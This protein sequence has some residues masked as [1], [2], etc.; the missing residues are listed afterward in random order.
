MVVRV[1][2]T[3][4][5]LLWPVGLVRFLAY[6]LIL[7]GPWNPAVLTNFIMNFSRFLLK[8]SQF[9]LRKSQENLA[10]PVGDDSFTPIYSNTMSRSKSFGNLRLSAAA[11]LSG[12]R[13]ELGPLLGA[14]AD[15]G[16][17]SFSRLNPGLTAG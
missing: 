17:S 15:S 14:V 7:F 13:S 12:N 1:L 5:S 9:R 16:G 10:G 2:D 3:G 11:P 6:S 4:I 8:Y